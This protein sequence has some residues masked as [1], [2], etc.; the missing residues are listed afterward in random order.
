MLVWGFLFRVLALI[1]FSFLATLLP[2]ATD[3][4]PL[5]AKS[6]PPSLPTHTL[7]MPDPGLVEVLALASS[8]AVSADG[9]A[10]I[11]LAEERLKQW[12]TTKGFYDALLVSSAVLFCGYGDR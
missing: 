11:R 12:E 1:F 3:S 6:L 5:T 8:Q 7:T 10:Q 2:I 4:L 9:A